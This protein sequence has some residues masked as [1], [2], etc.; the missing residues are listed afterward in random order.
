MKRNPLFNL[1]ER[2]PTIAKIGHYTRVF[3]ITSHVLKK[4]SYLPY[5]LF[6]LEQLIHALNVRKWQPKEHIVKNLKRNRI[7]EPISDWSKVGISHV[8]LGSEPGRKSNVK[9]Y[10]KCAHW[11]SLAIHYSHHHFG[12][13]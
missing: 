3:K 6:S 2:H 12:F 13:K 10:N 4:L 9:T 8:L 1:Q 11:K 7:Q 5:D